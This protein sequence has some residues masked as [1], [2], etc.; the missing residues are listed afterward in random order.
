MDS[1]GKEKA[2]PD[3][4][5]AITIKTDSISRNT[6]SCSNTNHPAA[7]FT[8]PLNTTSLATPKALPT[9]ISRNTPA[10][11]PTTPSPFPHGPQHLPRHEWWD[12]RE[13]NVNLDI[14]VVE[15]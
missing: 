4:S 14:R 10:Q 15:S 6:I 2:V 8:R 13:V 9:H 1:C 12:R 7:A 5:I 11:H 3:I